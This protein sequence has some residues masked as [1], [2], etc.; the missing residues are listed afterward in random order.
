MDVTNEEQVKSGVDETV[1]KFGRIDTVINNAGIQIISLIVRFSV[2]AWK[3]LFDIHMTGTLLVTQAAMRHMIELK[4]AGRIVVID[5]VHSVLASKNKAAYVA[6]KHAQVIFVRA[7]AK[8]GAEHNISS[9]LIGP[10]SVMTPLVEKQISEQAKELNIYKCSKNFGKSWLGN[11]N[12]ANT[13]VI[14]LLSY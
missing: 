1:K 11:V 10:G 12:K 3:K 2:S 9:N 14:Y 7:L 8:E 6:A 13:S 4:T 5:S